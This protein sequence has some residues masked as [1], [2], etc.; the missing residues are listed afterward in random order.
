MCHTI[1]VVESIRFDSIRFDESGWSSKVE[2]LR[3]AST[4]A[5]AIVP[6]QLN[7]PFDNT[8]DEP[9]RDEVPSSPR[10][11]DAARLVASSGR[12]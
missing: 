8:Y 4:R 3:A 11:L 9:D 1:D 5:Q 2:V 10:S 6:H 12:A 7:V